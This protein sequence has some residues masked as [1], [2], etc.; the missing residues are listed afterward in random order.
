MQTTY[1]VSHLSDQRQIATSLNI[2]RRKTDPLDLSSDQTTLL[3]DRPMT[4]TGDVGGVNGTYSGDLAAVNTTL[5]GNLVA[6]AGTF[7][8][9]IAAVNANISG[10]YEVASVQV[11]GPRQTGWT[12]DT[13]TA[14]K[15]AHATYTAGSTLTFSDPPTATEMSALATRLHSVEV[16]LQ[17][18]TRGQMAVKTALMTHGLLGT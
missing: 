2:A 17:G 11:V 14:E 9:D 13:G 6:V 8:A 12:A 4:V 16:A 7:S 18:A 3:V 5:T 15:T 1:R 10:V